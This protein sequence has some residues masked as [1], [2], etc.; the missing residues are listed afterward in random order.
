VTTRTGLDF[1]RPSTEAVEAVG[2]VLSAHWRAARS[3]A[4]SPYWPK[5]TSWVNGQASRLFAT[6]VSHSTY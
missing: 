3:A 6:R 2:K 1:W 4:N 5:P